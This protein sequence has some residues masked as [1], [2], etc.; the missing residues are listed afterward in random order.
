MSL[1]QSLAVGVLALGLGGSLL[2]I[3]SPVAAGEHYSRALGVLMTEQGREAPDFTLRD[4]AGKVHRL[5]DYRGR[6]VLLGFGATW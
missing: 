1:A 5:S 4:P 3:L 2:G 6:V